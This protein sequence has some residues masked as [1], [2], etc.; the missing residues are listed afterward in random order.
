MKQF[1][2]LIITAALLIPG[3][4]EAQKL[5]VLPD[6]ETPASIHVDSSNIYVTEQSKIYIYSMNDLSL[7][8]KFGKAGDGHSEFRIESGRN[9]SI[10]VSTDNI[11]VSSDGTLSFYSKKGDFINEVEIHPQ[12]DITVPFKDRLVSAAYY[13]R[14]GTGKSEEYISIHVNGLK[15]IT[16][17]REIYRSSLGQGSAIGFGDDGDLDIRL[18]PDILK[19]QAR[20]DKIFIGDAKKGL[21]FI[22][23]DYE[24]KVLY[25]INK[26]YENKRIT[27]EMKTAKIEKFKKRKI[28][29]R[30]REMIEFEIP[31]YLPAFSNFFISEGKM[32]VYLY[33]SDNINREILVLDQKGDEIGTI[34]VPLSDHSTVA[35]NRYYYLKKNVYE[36]WEIYVEDLFKDQGGDHDE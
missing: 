14:V 16:R 10:D 6:I 31:E 35:N 11:L 2:Y 17:I 27:E 30:H 22:V 28:W 7:V 8:R 12:A 4:I 21:Y 29:Q 5:G 33:S 26:D 32:F 18:F 24:G 19:F 36:E 9:I 34:S 13:I 20:D 3:K 25:E 15:D 23:Y 1:V